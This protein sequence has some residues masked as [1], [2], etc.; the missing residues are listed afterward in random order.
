MSALREWNRHFQHKSQIDFRLGDNS[1]EL[2]KNNPNITLHQKMMMNFEI[3]FW[4]CRKFLKW[5][6]RSAEEGQFIG[7]WLREIKTAWDYLRGLH[8]DVEQ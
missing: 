8:I 6:T 2:E 4:R 7:K 5:I 3:S 1:F